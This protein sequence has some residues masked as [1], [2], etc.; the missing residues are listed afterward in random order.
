MEASARGAVEAGGKAIGITSEYYTSSANRF[1]S[2]EIRTN[3]VVERL[4]RLIELAQGY[5]V[6][7]GGTGTLAELAMVWEYINKGVITPRP[8]V[9]FKPFWKPVIDTINLALA[10][11]GRENGPTSVKLFDTP[12]EAIAILKEEL[13]RTQGVSR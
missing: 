2:E 4:L 1:V 13:G 6:L 3:N 9:V 11:E 12:E 7:P 10:E 5:I 8:V